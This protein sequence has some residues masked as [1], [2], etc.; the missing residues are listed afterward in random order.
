MVRRHI[1]TTISSVGVQRSLAV[2]VY[3]LGAAAFT[4]VLSAC[5]GPA[6]STSGCAGQWTLQSLSS[7]TVETQSGELELLGDRGLSISMAM[8]PS[9]ALELNSLGE[10]T[11]GSW[12]DVDGGQVCR[13]DLGAQQLEASL[14]GD[15][16]TVDDGEI[17]AVFGRVS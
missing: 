9:G 4:G 1:R 16:L 17:R 8:A 3:A 7:P 12:A 10:V 2:L 13:L 5:S 6:S 15:L 11:T 14:D